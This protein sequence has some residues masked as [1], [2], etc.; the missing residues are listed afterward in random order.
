MT[1]HKFSTK[2]KPYY[3]K[4][5]YRVRYKLLTRFTSYWAEISLLPPERWPVTKSKDVGYYE[6]WVNH[7]DYPRTVEETNER[8]DAHNHIV[9]KM[10]A[11]V[12][13]K[14]TNVGRYTTV[15]VDD[16]DVADRLV[17]DEMTSRYLV[18]VVG[19]L[20]ENYDTLSKRVMSS[21]D[22]RPTLYYNEYR[23]KLPIRKGISVSEWTNF[24]ARLG[25]GDINVKVPENPR[26]GRSGLY[27][28]VALA[29]ND[30]ETSAHIVVLG[31]DIIAEIRRAVLISEI[32]R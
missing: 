16:K 25:S 32:N 4:F 29:C 9:E 17:A 31:G 30:V 20:I 18:D 3:G 21:E 5:R 6:W 28:D 10:L 12:S 13:Y 1:T 2:L 23:Y 11:G 8:R 22:I 15:F 24:V 26:F 19:P 7:Y 14:M 27:N